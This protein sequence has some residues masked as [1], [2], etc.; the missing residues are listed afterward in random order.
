VPAT[1]ETMNTPVVLLAQRKCGIP[2]TCR[3]W[4]SMC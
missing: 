4:R 3:S 2:M 1:L